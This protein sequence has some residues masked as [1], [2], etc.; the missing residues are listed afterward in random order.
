MRLK[1]FHVEGR[2]VVFAGVEMNAKP[3][4]H[5]KV[6]PGFQAVTRRRGVPSGTLKKFTTYDHMLASLAA[7]FVRRELGP[8]IPTRPKAAIVASL[9]ITSNNNFFLH[10]HWSHMI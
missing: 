8:T 9:C 7:L 3:W 1:G 6:V 10:Q 2:L 4:F 5:C